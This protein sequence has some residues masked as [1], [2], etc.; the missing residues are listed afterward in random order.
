[1][2]AGG[3]Y[4]GV[5]AFEVADLE[6]AV[7]LFGHG[8]EDVGLGG[9]GGEGLFDEEVES[10]GEEGGGGCG[11]VDGRDANAGGVEW[12]A[13][14]EEGFDGLEDGDVVVLGGCG[15][16]FGVGVDDGGEGYRGAGLFEF[17]VD[18][19]VI[20]AEGSDAYDRYSC[21]IFVLG[22]RATS[23]SQSA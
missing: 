18:A 8:D 10:G 21:F 9:G 16:G 6:D 14:C 22:Q 20:A 15:A 17:G 3:G 5:E 4:G 13:R 7:V 23:R 12:D 1:V 11:V 2:G 19:E